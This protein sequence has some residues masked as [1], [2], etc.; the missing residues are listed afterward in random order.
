MCLSLNDIGGDVEQ[1]KEKQY[2]RQM[3]LNLASLLKQP[4]V[5]RSTYSKYPTKSG[6]LVSLPEPGKHTQ[7]SFSL[8][9]QLNS[10]DL[11]LIVCNF[12][13]NCRISSN[14]CVLMM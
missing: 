14:L 7:F 13:L 6:K 12:L 1:N 5:S 4:V 3:K 10:E 9:N 2:I 11:H 8:H